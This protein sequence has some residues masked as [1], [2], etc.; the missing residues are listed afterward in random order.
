M[1]NGSLVARR[2]FTTSSTSTVVDRKTSF[3]QARSLNRRNVTVPVGLLPPT[4]SAVSR[5]VLLSRATGVEA[6]VVM[7]G[8]AG[9]AA[10]TAAMQVWAQGAAAAAAGAG[11]TPAAGLAAT[12]AVWLRVV[13]GEGG[14]GVPA[15]ASCGPPTA[16]KISALAAASTPSRRVRAGPVPAQVGTPAGHEPRP[17]SIG[18]LAVPARRSD[19]T[20]A[21]GGRRSRDGSRRAPSRPGHR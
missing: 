17:L 12:M 21:P 15:P 10:V 2:V 16:A 19:E 7:V 4:T 3:V 1:L 14:T 8:V 9:A 6:V 18:A 13:G 5:T 11:C 20:L